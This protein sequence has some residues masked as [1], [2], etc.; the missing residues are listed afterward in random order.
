MKASELPSPLKVFISS[1]VAQGPVYAFF[2]DNKQTPFFYF[3]SACL[4]VVNSSMLFVLVSILKK[5]HAPMFGFLEDEAYWE[6]EFADRRRV[7]RNRRV[8]M[9]LIVIVWAIVVYLLVQGLLS[10]HK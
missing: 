4:F 1:L 2:I 10:S 9:G 6:Q 7:T 5:P 8:Q 3:L